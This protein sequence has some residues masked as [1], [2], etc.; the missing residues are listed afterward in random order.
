MKKTIGLTNVTRK[1]AHSV[2]AV[3]SQV[4]RATSVVLLVLL[5]MMAGR[6]QAAAV[7]TTQVIGGINTLTGATGVVV[8]GISYDVTFQDGT[9][10]QVFSGCDSPAD[11]LFNTASSAQAASLQLV[12]QVFINGPVGQFDTPGLTAGCSDNQ[13]CYTFTPY[14]LAADT[15][16]TAVATNYVSDAGEAGF[17]GNLLSTGTD[18]ATVSAWNWAVWS[19]SAQA[20]PEP[21]SLVLAGTAAF[22]LAW[23]QRR[24]RNN[25]DQRVG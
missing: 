5:L 23:L 24:R 25:V 1:Q 19:P 7:L 12:A 21:N 17:I 11:F 6:A 18:T 9:C 20:V 8:S 13:T 4:A 10:I 16:T 2:W 15:V 14:S 3:I 22:A